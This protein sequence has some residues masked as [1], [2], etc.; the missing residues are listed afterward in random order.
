MDED[1]SIYGHDKKKDA[2]YA[3]VHGRVPCGVIG[4]YSCCETREPNRDLVAFCLPDGSSTEFLL[5][6]IETKSPRQMWRRD[7]FGKGPRGVC[8]LERVHTAPCTREPGSLHEW[9]TWDW[10]AALPQPRRWPWLMRWLLSLLRR[11]GGT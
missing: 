11:Q 9:W 3:P 1:T 10:E 6:G 7:S 5:S 4:Y 8:L 2:R